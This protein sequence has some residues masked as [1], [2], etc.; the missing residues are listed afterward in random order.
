MST[1]EFT[2]ARLNA[3]MLELSQLLDEHHEE[4][5]R[6]CHEFS[7]A[8]DA[9]RLAKANAFLTASGTV[10]ARKAQVDKV[11]SA[12]RRRAHLAEELMRAAFARVKST[13]AQ[14]SARQS[15]AQVKKSELQQLGRDLD[16]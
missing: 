13:Q 15:I 5:V 14:L 2:P 3:D 4:L 9:Y 8:E 7:E 11:T 6:A 1:Y 16:A 10:E 12:E